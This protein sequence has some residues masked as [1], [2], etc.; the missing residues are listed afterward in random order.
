M[1]QPL[2]LS[3]MVNLSFDPK[4][5]RTTMRER[6]LKKLAH[7]VEW[8]EEADLMLNRAWCAAEDLAQLSDYHLGGFRGEERVAQGADPRALERENVFYQELMDELHQVLRTL[9]DLPTKIEDAPVEDA[10][11]DA[12]E[13]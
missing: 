13:P 9:R 7:I 2:H 12:V 3:T 4:Y 10:V 6:Q 8:I 1:D 11:E 5:S